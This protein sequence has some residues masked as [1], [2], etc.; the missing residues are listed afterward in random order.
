V[1]RKYKDIEYSALLDQ[2]AQYTLDYTK[3]LNENASSQLKEDCQKTIRR[4]LAEINIRE[5]E[6]T[7]NDGTGRDRSSKS[8]R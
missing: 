3:M 2:L 6:S 1:N 7:K 8:V 4:I 5:S